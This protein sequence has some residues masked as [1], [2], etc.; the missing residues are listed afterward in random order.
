MTATNPVRSGVSVVCMSSPIQ[1]R[2]IH[3]TAEVQELFMSAYTKHAT[4]IRVGDTITHTR[5][6]T[7]TE[8]TSVVAS[9]NLCLRQG[10]KYG[11]DALL[12]PW[13]RR[14]YG[15]FKVVGGEFVYG[16]NISA[17]S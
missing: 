5:P 11:E 6:H 4:S 13:D 16:R 12:I 7:A 10:D 17:S 8:V 1:T 3:R 14:A 9:I 15:Y 2:D